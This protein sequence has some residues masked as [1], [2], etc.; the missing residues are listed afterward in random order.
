MPP[1]LCTKFS[2]D[3]NKGVSSKEDIASMENQLRKLVLT[4]KDTLQSMCAS[5]MESRESFLKQVV[6]YASSLDSLFQS[7]EMSGQATMHRFVEIVSIDVDVKSIHN[8]LKQLAS[9]SNIVEGF[10]HRAGG[11]PNTTSYSECTTRVEL[12]DIGHS[13]GSGTF[14]QKTHVT[15]AH[16]SQLSQQKL[17]SEFKHLFGHSVEVSVTAILIGETIAA[18]SVILPEQIHSE[19]PIDIPPSQNVYP[20]ITVWLGAGESAVRSNDLPAMVERGEAV[21]VVLGEVATVS[22]TFAYWFI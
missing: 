13:E 16:F 3:S 8:L 10:L 20:H 11:L 2:I 12:T 7:N 5:E 1:T 4:H 9:E 22:G 14:V 21:Q 6:S 19:T 17:Y 18:L 15:M